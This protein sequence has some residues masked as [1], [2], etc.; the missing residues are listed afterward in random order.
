MRIRLATSQDLNAI[1]SLLANDPLGA[2]R[3]C[4][5]DPLP[6]DYVR[7]FAEIESDGRQELVVAEVDGEVVGTLQLTIIPYLTYQGGTR[8]QIEAVRVAGPRRGE[9]V[10]A[11]LI[12]WAV[13]RAK[14]RGCHL[15][16]LTTDKSRMDA[17]RF[18]EELGFRATH[19]GMKMKLAGVKSNE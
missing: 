6:E 18:Y 4:A 17:K 8:A 15:V 16:Q 14:E 12:Q 3:E 13:V 1:V 11:R 10:G 2:T 5:A 9:G 19:E 7:A